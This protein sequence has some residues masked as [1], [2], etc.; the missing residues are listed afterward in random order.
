MFCFVLTLIYFNWRLII[1]TYCVGFCHT[2]TWISHGYTCVPTFW[3]PLPPPS[4]PIPWGCPRLWVPFFRNQTCT[5]IIYMVVYMFQCY[6]LKSSHTHLLPHSPKVCSLHL[7][8]FTSVSLLL[9]CTED[10]HYHLSKFHI[11]VIIYCIGVSLLN[12]LHSV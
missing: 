9:S 2:L 6:S 11:Y 8:L 5:Y 7:F 3:I 1:Y 4:P 10:H 12:L